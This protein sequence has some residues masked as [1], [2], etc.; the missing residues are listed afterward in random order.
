MR[1]LLLSVRVLRRDDELS[2]NNPP[3]CLTYQRESLTI[4]CQGDDGW[5]RR[6][7]KGFFTDNRELRL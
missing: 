4:S 7:S 1:A 2:D 6:S 5:I 3:G